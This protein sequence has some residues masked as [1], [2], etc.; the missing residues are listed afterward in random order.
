V[1][2]CRRAPCGRGAT[3]LGRLGAR[4]MLREH[5]ASFVSPE[6]V[7]GA[8]QALDA[9]LHD[10]HRAA[11]ALAAR[12]SAGG[13]R[14]MA[15]VLDERTRGPW[16]EWLRTVAEREHQQLMAA[17]PHG[18]LA[19]LQVPVYL[20]HGARDPVIPSIETLYLARDVPRP[21]LRAV[22]ITDLLRHA[23]FPEPPSLT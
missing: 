14:F 9:Y 3:W 12:L 10:Q 2:S 20:I 17:S 23:E 4:V 1:Y 5:L 15:V 16:V 22:V 11:R 13:Q 18:Q 6:D 7:P 21:F 8:Q 19:R